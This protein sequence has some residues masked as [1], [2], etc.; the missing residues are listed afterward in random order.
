VVKQYKKWLTRGIAPVLLVLS[1]SQP[2][3]A[4]PV[5]LTLDES[6]SLALKNNPSMKTA[7]SGREQSL[8]AVE[9]AKA[10]KGLT[11]GYT[12]TD[13]RYTTY[14]SYKVD[15][16][17]YLRY[18]KAYYGV[19]YYQNA[20]SL[21]LPIY[22]GGSVEGQID[23]A[24]LSLKVS[25]LSIEAT[26]Q[27][28]KQTV[29]ND[30]FSVLQYRNNLAV[31]KE[32]VGNYVDHL[33]NVQ[34]QYDAGTVAKTDVLSSQVSLANAQA[35]LIKAQNNYDLAVANLNNAIGLSLDTEVT[36]KEELKYEKYTNTLDACSEYAIASR[37]EMAQYKAKVDS[38][39]A[40]V[41]V[42]KSGYR[43][44][45]SLF[46]TEG[47]NDDQFAGFDNNT[48]SVGLT[49]TWSIFDAGLTDSKVKQ[50]KYG[51]NTA[52]VQAGQ[53]RDTILLEVRQYY[54]SL[55]EAEKRIETTQ[56]AVNQAQENLKIAEVRYTAGVGTNLDVLDA[57]L[58]LN[59][60]KTNYIQALYDYNTSKTSLEKA[61]GVA[62]K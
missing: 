52:E 2:V 44:S 20:L 8:W 40:A 13:E 46:A 15:S 21:K 33:K 1:F 48:W 19:D 47:W 60:S 7:L 45:V 49:A 30:Y 39:N 56:V 51:V 28:L 53:E 41:N 27:Q 5:A 10:G 4:A 58:A 22:T 29:T 34:L 16:A 38:A 59:Q 17:G 54:L 62:V 31:S 55:R 14:S 37:P 3:F 42:A 6:I 18:G 24:K 26:K 23:Q 11:L 12:H 32:T 35:S 57:V 25:D 9:Q 36:L 61:M 43:P 50:A